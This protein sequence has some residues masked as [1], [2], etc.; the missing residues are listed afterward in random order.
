[1]TK[2]MAADFWVSE[3]R[4]DGEFYPGDNFTAIKS[5]NVTRT[6]VAGALRSLWIVR[7]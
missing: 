6:Y 4:F 3:R 1:M 7:S 5:E 2:D